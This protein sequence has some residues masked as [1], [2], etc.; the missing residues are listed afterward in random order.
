MSARQ[1]DWA[2]RTLKQLKQQLGGCCADCGSRRK[3]EFDCIQPAGHWH[4]RIGLTWRASFYRQQAKA[5]NLQLLCRPCHIIKTSRET[6]Q[7]A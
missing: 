5:D 7:A 2:Q 3:L 6:L 1:V 4:H